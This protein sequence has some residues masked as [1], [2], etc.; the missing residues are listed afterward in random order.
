MSKHIFNNLSLVVARSKNKVIGYKGGIPW[1]CAEDRAYFKALT[2]GRTCITGRKTFESLPNM[3]LPC[4]RLL[5]LSKT[6]P[7]AASEHVHTVRTLE[8]AFSLCTQEKEF[9]CIGGSQL[10]HVCL[11]YAKKIYITEIH[12]EYDGDTFFPDSLLVNFS[13]TDT[14][15]TA[16]CRYSTYV[17]R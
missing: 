16:Q 8:A 13:L 4:R 15:S 9:F 14:V 11:P 5:V 1:D 3:S 6:A 10:Y 12:G 7:S 17:R 2:W